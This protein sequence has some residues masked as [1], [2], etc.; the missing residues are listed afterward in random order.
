MARC[1]SKATQ[2]HQCSLGQPRPTYTRASH[3]SG[4]RAFGAPS[5]ARRRLGRQTRLRPA[6]T[7]P[8]GLAAPRHPARP[9]CEPGWQPLV[10]AAALRGRAAGKTHAQQPLG[11]Q[12]MSEAGR[13]CHGGLYSAGLRVSHLAV[14][15]ALWPTTTGQKKKQSGGK[16]WVSSCQLA[17]SAGIACRARQATASFKQR[18]RCL[19]FS[20]GQGEAG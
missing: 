11:G 1:Q 13:T 20:T 15:L 19:M 5:C 9:T 18:L 2:A 10:L 7:A 3:P 4:C 17:L 16:W 14:S 12:V 6:H 8:A